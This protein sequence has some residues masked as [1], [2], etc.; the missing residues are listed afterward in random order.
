MIYVCSKIQFIENY[1]EAEFGKKF[2]VK[3]LSDKNYYLENSFNNDDILILDLDQFES[4]DDVM[5]YLLQIPKTLKVISILEEPKLAHGAYMIKKGFKSYLGK[6]TNKLIIEQVIETVKNDNV[7]LYPELMNYII[8]HISINVEQT[9]SQKLISK[10]SKKENEVA[11]LVADGLSNK[12]ISIK[13]D[14]QIVTVK[15]HISSI[16]SKLNIKDR[17]SLAIL[18]NK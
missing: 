9:N 8:K 17:V 1:W 11:N 16:F 5:D 4:I 12:D 7:W 15:K 13:L 3:I 10:L 2:D 18:I 6:K 14:V